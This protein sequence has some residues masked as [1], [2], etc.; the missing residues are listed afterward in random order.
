MGLMKTMKQTFQSETQAAPVVE[1]RRGDIVESRHRGYILVMDGDENIK[2]SEGSPDVVTY[3]RSASK[4]QQAI[5]LITTGAAKAFGFTEKEIAIACGSHNGDPEHTETVASMLGKIGL[6]PSFLR[7]GTHTPYSPEAAK[8]LIESGRKPDVLQ[9]NCSGKHAGMLA[10]AKHIGAPVETYYR[11][12][13]PVQQLIAETISHFSGVE[14][15]EIAV[16]IDGCGVPV[17][18]M[19]LTGMAR[20][21]ARLIRPPESFDADLRKACDRIVRSMAEYPVMIGGETES[22]DTALM[23]ATS[24]RVIAKAGAEG[25]FTGAVLAGS[26]WPSGLAIVVKIEDGDPGRRARR[27]VVTEV[28]RQLGVLSESQL[29]QLSHYANQPIKNHRGD[30][31]GEVSAAFTLATGGDRETSSG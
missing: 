31:V 4:P 6:D 30:V 16:G 14:T 26:E 24:G 27:P 9:N 29:D 22:Q 20:M 2:A 23:K 15:R 8:A 25:L 21:Y 12:D 18:G 17:F 5:P 7:C 10:V 11:L 1:V 28:F 13:H 19:P 3:L